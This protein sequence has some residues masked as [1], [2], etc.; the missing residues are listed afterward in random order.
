VKQGGICE[1]LF[2]WEALSLWKTDSL[3]WGTLSHGAQELGNHALLEIPRTHKS[4]LL[5][6]MKGTLN[7]PTTQCRTT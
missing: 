1:Y 2:T 4:F 7:N 6:Q 5:T 3:A